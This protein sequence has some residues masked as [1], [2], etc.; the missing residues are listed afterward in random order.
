MNFIKFSGS[1]VKLN[2]V[3]YNK[4][5][6]LFSV[7]IF[8]ETVNCANIVY[9]THSYIVAFILHKLYIIRTKQV[10]VHKYDNSLL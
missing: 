9:F 2:I 6:M 4:F 7:N 8:E 3:R 10:L 1:T 5:N